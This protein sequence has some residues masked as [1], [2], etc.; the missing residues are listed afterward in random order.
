MSSEDTVGQAFSPGM[1]PRKVALSVV[2]TSQTE[3]SSLEEN[4]F[5]VMMSKEDF[6]CQR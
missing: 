1:C 2:M 3:A 5:L 4:I 6:C